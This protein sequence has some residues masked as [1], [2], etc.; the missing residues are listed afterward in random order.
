MFTEIAAPI[1]PCDQP[2]SRCSGL[3]SSP[4]IVV[5]APAATIAQAAATA[6]HQARCTRGS[7]STAVASP[8]CVTDIGGQPGQWTRRAVPVLSAPTAGC[9][10]ARPGRVD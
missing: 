2:N 3:I 1:L 6:T 7:G 5:Q 4:D 10:P 9:P 8:C